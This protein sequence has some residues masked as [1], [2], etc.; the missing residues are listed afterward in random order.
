MTSM[1]RQ[2]AMAQ[3]TDKSIQLIAF[4]DHSEKSGKIDN[5]ANRNY[6]SKLSD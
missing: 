5:S 1:D 2:V 3:Q 6:L 4:S